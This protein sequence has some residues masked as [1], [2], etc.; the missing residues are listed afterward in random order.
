MKSVYVLITKF[1]F[2]IT[3]SGY[4]SDCLSIRPN[5]LRC[6]LA[7]HLRYLLAC[8]TLSGTKKLLA[9]LPKDHPP[10]QQI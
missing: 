4:K 6:L 2:S 3:S 1:P 5:G 7:I 8:R 10:W 9:F